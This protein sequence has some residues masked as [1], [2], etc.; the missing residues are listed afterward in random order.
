MAEGA[1][2][3]PEEAD[4]NECA[5]DDLD[6]TRLGEDG[7]PSSGAIIVR[8]EPGDQPEEVIAALEVSPRLELL[9]VLREQSWAA[10][11]PQAYFVVS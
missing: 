7:A 4:L 6:L 10:K 3:W 2:P 11:A 9:K 8:P 5:L 1:W